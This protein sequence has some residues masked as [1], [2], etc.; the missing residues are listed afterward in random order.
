MEIDVIKLE[1]NIEYA[2]F[3]TI[4]TESNKYLFL[5]NIQNYDDICIR[6]IIVKDG[7]EYLRKLEDEEFEEV[8][9]LF[10]EKHIRKE[11][12]NEK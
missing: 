7:K 8:M 2:I 12:E 9:T 11:E 3:D 4:E 6:K 1:D 5:G 10:N